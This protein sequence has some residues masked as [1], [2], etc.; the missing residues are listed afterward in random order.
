MLYGWDGTF[1]ILAHLAGIHR[2]SW[3]WVSVLQRRDNLVPA[4]KSELEAVAARFTAGL[5]ARVPIIA[6]SAGVTLLAIDDTVR[7]T[8]FG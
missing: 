1:G 7:S 3:W 5:A 4:R 2:R 8:R 6:A